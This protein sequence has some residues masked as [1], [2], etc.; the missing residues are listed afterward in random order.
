MTANVY[1]WQSEWEKHGMRFDQPDKPVHYYQT[2]LNAIKKFDFLD[3]LKKASIE[4]NN[5]KYN[6]TVVGK[7]AS[8]YVKRQVEISCNKDSEGNIQLEEMRVCYTRDG[9]EKSCPYKFN[10]CGDKDEFIQF[11]SAAAPSFFC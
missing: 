1:F 2:P 4:P 6:R 7:V 8:D 11:P 9:N 10:Y 5:G 3:I